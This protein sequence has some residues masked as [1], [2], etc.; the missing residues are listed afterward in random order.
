[1]LR[2]VL[3]GYTYLKTTNREKLLDS[4][5]LPKDTTIKTNPLVA[6]NG[7]QH[8]EMKEGRPKLSKLMEILDI[9][10]L[11]YYTQNTNYYF[12]EA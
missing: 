1:M 12:T 7:H 9:V 4:F 3:E 8:K 11:Y 2:C 10:P 5:N 6:L